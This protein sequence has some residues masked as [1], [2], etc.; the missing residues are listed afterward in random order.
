QPEADQELSQAESLRLANKVGAAFIKAQ[1]EQY[2]E[3]PF[4]GML[5]TILVRLMFLIEPDFP[6]HGDQ[7]LVCP[8]LRRIPDNLGQE[9]PLDTI[10]SAIPGFDCL[11][12]NIYHRW[13]QLVILMIEVK[14]L[15]GQQKKK[16]QKTKGKRK[17]GKR[18][19]KPR[20]KTPAKVPSTQSTLYASNLH[21]LL[22]HTARDR[23]SVIRLRLLLLPRRVSAAEET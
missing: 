19:K 1:L 7:F 16:N 4:Y 15:T 9:F 20:R 6:E 14:R 22:P 17:A 12:M 10:T 5:N 21:L 23:Q 8:Q 3:H 11:L 2:S 18:R 13:R